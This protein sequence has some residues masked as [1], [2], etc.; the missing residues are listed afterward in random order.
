MDKKNENNKNQF[1]PVV[2][3]LGHVDHGKTALLDKIRET[4]VAQK[5]LGGI[6]QKIGASQIEI[7]SRTRSFFKH[8]V[9]R[10]VGRG[11]RAFNCG[12]K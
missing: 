5:E 3:V 2:S 8:E 7:Y 11:Y 4:T 1:P 6:T 9:S 10:G 12:G